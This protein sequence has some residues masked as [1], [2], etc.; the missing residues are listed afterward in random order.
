MVAIKPTA[1]VCS[2]MGMVPIEKL[3]WDSTAKN[4]APIAGRARRKAL[5][6]FIIVN[7]FLKLW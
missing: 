6:L 3:S 4:A 5:F 7:L 1:K 2:V